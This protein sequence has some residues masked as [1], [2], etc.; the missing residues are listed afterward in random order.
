MENHLYEEASWSMAFANIFINIKKI[1]EPWQSEVIVEFHVLLEL[2]LNLI[3]ILHFTS[4]KLSQ[5]LT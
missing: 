2:G 1:E 3:Y 5:A 4:K